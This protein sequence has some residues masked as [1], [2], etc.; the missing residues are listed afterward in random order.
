MEYKVR[1]G[2]GSERREGRREG[3]R[4]ERGH[5]YDRLEARYVLFAADKNRKRRDVVRTRTAQYLQHAEELHQ[6]YLSP[7]TPTLAKVCI[8]GVLRAHC[9]EGAS[10]TRCPVCQMSR[11]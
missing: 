7:R 2:E 6:K 5:N 3:R 11:L 9:D 10:N 8:P 1:G 4:E